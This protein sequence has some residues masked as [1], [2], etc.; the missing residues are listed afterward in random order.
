MDI[1]G[2]SEGRPAQATGAIRG[3]TMVHESRPMSVTVVASAN[4]DYRGAAG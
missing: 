1:P 3:T 4:A 2:A